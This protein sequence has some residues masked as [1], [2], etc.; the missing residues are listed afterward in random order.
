MRIQV[1]PSATGYEGLTRVA[2][3]SYE[4]PVET[5]DNEGAYFYTDDQYELAG[6]CEKLAMIVGILGW[7]VLFA[8]LFKGKMIGVETMAVIQSVF[9]GLI[10][11]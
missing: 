10:A 11:L 8:G 4:W 1:N 5:N 2:S 3:A 9:L 6:I 7:F